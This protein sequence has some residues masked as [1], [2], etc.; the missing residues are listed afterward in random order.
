MKEWRRQRPAWWIQKLHEFRSRLPPS[1]F[2][3]VVCCNLARRWLPWL[4]LEPCALLTFVIRSL[5]AV[6]HSLFVFLGCF[7][8]NVRFA[9]R[10]FVSLLGITVTKIWAQ[11][12]CGETHI[13]IKMI[14][15]IANASLSKILTEILTYKCHVVVYV[16][17]YHLD[18]LTT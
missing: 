11:W 1:A 12:G 8:R 5:P 7:M 3:V 18:K 9:K 2:D 13:Q 17:S 10:P 14:A 15:F 6:A 16:R 4:F